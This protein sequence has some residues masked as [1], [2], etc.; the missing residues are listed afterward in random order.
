MKN[1]R[2]KVTFSRTFNIKAKNAEEATRKL[3]SLVDEVEFSSDVSHDGYCPFED[4]EPEE[5]ETEET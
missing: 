2:Q 1:Y 5:V 4:E 3:E